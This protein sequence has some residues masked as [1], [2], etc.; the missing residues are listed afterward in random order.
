[1]AAGAIAFVESC[2]ICDGAGAESGGYAPDLRAAASTLDLAAFRD[3][4]I[5]GS[6]R[7]AGMPEFADLPADEVIAIQHYIRHQ[8]MLD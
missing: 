3:V 5:N 7:A 1:M 4:V 8:A 2:L 6:R